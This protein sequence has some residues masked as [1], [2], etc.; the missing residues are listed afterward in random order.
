MSYDHW[1]TTEPDDL[2][3]PEPDDLDDLDVCPDCRFV[4]RP[5]ELPHRAQEASCAPWVPPRPR[6][7]YTFQTCTECAGLGRHGIEMCPVCGGAGRC[8]QR[9]RR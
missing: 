1:K 5:D 2:T 8:Y 7:R 3:R 6:P 9:D 4:L